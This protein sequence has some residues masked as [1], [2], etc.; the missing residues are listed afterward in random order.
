MLLMASRVLILL[1]LSML[2]MMSMVLILSM[3]IVNI[4]YVPS[5]QISFRQG[6]HI[7]TMTFFFGPIPAGLLWKEGGWVEGRGRVPLLLL[8]EKVRAIDMAY[9]GRYDG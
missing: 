3:N 7:H 5:D 1:M 8:P 6:C 2:L 9:W 4:V